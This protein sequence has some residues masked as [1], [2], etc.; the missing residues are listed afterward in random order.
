MNYKKE[1]D[2]NESKHIISLPYNN[3][4][5][6]TDLS[7]D[8]H[9]FTSPKYN[10]YKTN[11]NKA[12]SISAII[13]KR[14]GALNKNYDANQNEKKVDLQSH[15]TND[16]VKI[17]DNKL[18]LHK[19]RAVFNQEFQE[20]K[21]F[22]KYTEPITEIKKLSAFENFTTSSKSSI[23][24]NRISS[25]AISENSSLNQKNMSSSENMTSVSN[26][27]LIHK[28]YIQHALTKSWRAPLRNLL[29]SGGKINPTDGQSNKLSAYILSENYQERLLLLNEKTQQQ[30][31]Q[32]ELYN[33]FKS[34]RSI[35]FSRPIA[36]QP[37]SNP[38][39]LI[40]QHKI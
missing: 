35:T 13:D 25:R 8:T 28:R 1:N 2:S 31:K 39:F 6:D 37:T 38:N 33:Q 9:L 22:S 5:I 34:K 20:S 30:I 40:T 4:K 16:T 17:R 14:K 21:K 19:S 7:N 27:C 32:R 24:K 3:L 12:R 11:S 36:P 26:H 15:C 29:D 10:N 23:N 18:L